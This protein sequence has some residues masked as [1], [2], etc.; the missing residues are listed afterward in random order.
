MDIFKRCLVLGL[1]AILILATFRAARGKEPMAE[2]VVSMRYL[3]QTGTSHAHLY[4]YRAD[5]K[6]LRQLTT[7][8]TGQDQNPVFA[9]DGETIV[10]TRLSGAGT[11][12]CWSIEPRGT[13]LHPL[14]EA[15]DWYKTAKPSP[16]F[17]DPPEDEKIPNPPEYRSA[18]G[19]VAIVL[20]LEKGDPANDIDGE[21]HGKDYALDD[22]KSKY[23]DKLGDLPGFLGLW[24]LLECPATGGS[25][26]FLIADPLR[27]AFFNL[28]L[29]S[30]DGG[31]VFALDIVEKRLVRLSPNN[32][33]PFPL[34]GEAAF[35]TLAEQRYVPYGD[36]QHTANCSYVEHWDARFNKV[37]YAQE[38][39]AAVCGGASMYR[40]G[41]TPAVITIRD[42]K[43]GP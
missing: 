37:R 1:A 28:H 20:T 12:E 11:T 41:K 30:T 39:S 24:N 43:S 22:G 27:A 29:N 6:L 14:T 2:I 19:K 9:P 42:P 5:G 7:D 35:L 26:R 15:P 17:V 33:V 34:P 18:D 38:K 40:P 23:D 4:L 25:G 10:F 36:G 32:A 31:T 8:D 21:G 13:G 3:Q 16:S